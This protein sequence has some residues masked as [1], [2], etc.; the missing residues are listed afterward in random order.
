MNNEN[1]FKLIAIRPLSDCNERFLKNLNKGEIYQFYNDYKFLNKKNKEVGIND[2]VSDIN[3]ASSVPKD[4]YNIES[5]DGHNLNINISAVVGKNGSG[6][7]SLM[8]L[9]YA[10]IYLFSINENI[11]YP[12]VNSIN[13]RKKIILK[14]EKE[15]KKTQNEIV[16]TEKLRTFQ[17]LSKFKNYQTNDEKY[18]EELK[19]QFVLYIE[20]ENILKDLDRK[21]TKNLNEVK[22]DLNNIELIKT[23]LA[24]EL[25]YEIDSLFFKLSIKK[26]LSKVELINKDLAISRSLVIDDLL[27]KPF[28]FSDYFFYTISINYSH[29][30][31]NSLFLGDWITNLFHKNDGY[32]TPIVIN[33]MRTEGN[34]DINKEIKFAKYRL[35]SNILIEAI[36]SKKDDKIF[37][38]DNQYIDKVRFKINSKKVK[39]KYVDDKGE[40]IS[41]SS[42]ELNL[43]MDLYDVFFPTHELIQLRTSKNKFIDLISNYIIQKISKISLTYEGFYEGYQNPV[44]FPNNKNDVFLQK[45]VDDSSHITTKLKQALN[46]LIHN[47]NTNFKKFEELILEDNEFVDFTLNELSDWMENPD[48]FEIINHIPPSIFDIEFI[49]KDS[50][51]ID[52]TTSTFNDLSSGEQQMIHAIQ[53]VIYHLNNLQSVNYSIV[54]RV[55][56][57]SIN[58]VFDEIELYFHP[59]Y[60]RKFIN[61]LLKSLEKIY[62][63]KEGG[64]ESINIQFLTHSPFILSDIPTNNILKLENGNK[65]VL[66]Y[67]EKTFGANIHEQL[68]HSFF[69]EST[70][71]EFAI[72]KIEKIVEFY[73]LVRNSNDKEIITLRKEYLIIKD[74]FNFIMNSI[75]EEIIRGLLE[76]H[77]GYIE[78]Y[79][80]I[81]EN[82][83]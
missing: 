25:Y 72:K 23:Q 62:L 12:N 83:E 74:E 39:N 59:E 48:F 63:G 60:Q 81:N 40:I 45:L 70:I 27:D 77:I 9:F 54:K 52:N 41:G 46:F 79:L 35:L 22:N 15:D 5:A 58:I 33:P 53:S 6:K 75:G 16:S 37:I 68:T 64:I 47:N 4:F 76:N 30:G 32:K 73:Y 28:N 7:S 8:E 11:L 82:Y 1:N 14:K 66:E 24:V 50:K 36:H 21:K 71:G 17:M 3:F 57:K 38:T 65:L 44:L 42:K 56:Y 67:P 51:S 43:L 34:Y 2:D 78:E 20:R 29:Y 26:G 80:S 10:S 13:E 69:M 19:K 55:S 18:F 61:E 49:L 31:L